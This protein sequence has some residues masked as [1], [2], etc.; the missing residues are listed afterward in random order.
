MAQTNPAENQQAEATA[1]SGE[2]RIHQRAFDDEA[3]LP[4]T[5]EVIA[6]RPRITTGAYAIIRPPQK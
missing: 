5:P 6:K 1:R 3:V 4:P 2:H